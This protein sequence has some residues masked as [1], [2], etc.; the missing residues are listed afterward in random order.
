MSPAG[1][2]IIELRHA[3]KFLTGKLVICE[4]INLNNYLNLNGEQIVDQNIEAVVLIARQGTKKLLEIGNG[5]IDRI[6]QELSPDRLKW[7]SKAKMYGRVVDKHARHNLCFSDVFQPPNYEEGKGTVY[8]YSCVPSLDYLRKVFP[9]LLGNNASDL[10]AE[11]NLYY[12]TAKCGIGFH[13]DA[14]RKKVIAIRLY[15]D[16]PLDYQWFYK[17]QPVG[18]RVSINLQ[19]GDLYIM[20]EKATGYDWKK[21][22]IYTLRHAAG[23]EKYRTI[24]K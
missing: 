24:K 21:K 8:P 20:S 19:A 3:E 2:S 23:C 18:Q 12:D 7:D 13:G 22:N 11:G 10:Q 14:E 5:S 1:F 15:S 17:S 4:W 9:Y 16:M 6:E